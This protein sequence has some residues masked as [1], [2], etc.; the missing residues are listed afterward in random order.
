[1][2][3][4]PSLKPKQVVK[5]L[6]KN[7]FAELRQIGSHLH[8]FHPEQKIRVTVPMHNKDLKRK[9]L[10]AILRQAKISLK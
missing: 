1:M 7:G 5:I 8:L 2:S 3:R 4:L 6:R 10:A 9:T